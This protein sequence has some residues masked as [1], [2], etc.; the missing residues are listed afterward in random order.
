SLVAPEGPVYQAGT[1]S[2]NPL[3]VTAGIAT[4]RLLRQAGIYPEL[5]RRSTKL[6]EGLRQAA[7]KAGVAATVNQVGSMFT[8]FFTPQTVT[9]WDT[10]KTAETARFG[11][12]FSA[13]PEGGGYF[14]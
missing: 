9:N 14:V 3:T 10:A 6:A 13:L 7:Q 4:L 5:E 12:G 2:G 1:L 8:L 11:G